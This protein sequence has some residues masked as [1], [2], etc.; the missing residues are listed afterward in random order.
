MLSASMVDCHAATR[1]ERDSYSR[2]H[3]YLLQEPSRKAE[4]CFREKIRLLTDPKWGWMPLT[5]IGRLKQTLQR[6]GLQFLRASSK[7]PGAGR[8][9]IPAGMT[10]DLWRLEPRAWPCHGVKIRNPKH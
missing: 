4:A 7:R 8:R 3:W 1:H 10:P 2:G 9:R 5:L 6:L